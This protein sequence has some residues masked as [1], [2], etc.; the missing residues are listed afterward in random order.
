MYTLYRS[1]FLWREAV[2][3]FE[4]I[5][6]AIEAIPGGVVHWAR[7]E[8]GHDAADAMARDGRLY[9]VEG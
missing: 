9:A 3:Q 4:T 5:E 1:H 7:D 8:D 2:G 6:A